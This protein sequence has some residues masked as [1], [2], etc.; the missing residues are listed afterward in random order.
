MRS[1][2]TSMSFW[3]PVAG[4]EMLNCIAD[5]HIMSVIVMWHEDLPHHVPGSQKSLLTPNTASLEKK[6]V[7][8]Y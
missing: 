1:S 8:L 6:L 2:S 5:R 3:H 7:S 4:F